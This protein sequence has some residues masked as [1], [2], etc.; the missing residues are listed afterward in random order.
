MAKYVWLGGTVNLGRFGTVRRGDVLNM[1]EKEEESIG[2]N[3]P[4]GSLDPRFRAFKDGEK[5][6]DGAGLD[7]PEGFEKLTK[8]GQA[9]AR[10]ASEE[11]RRRL[12]ALAQ[13][14]NPKGGTPGAGAAG[15]P[16]PPLTAEQQE[17]ARA[18]A[19]ERARR[20]QL[21]AANANTDKENFREMTKAELLEVVEEIRR[22]GTPVESIPKNASRNAV[23]RA[24]LVA[25]GLDTDDVPEDEGTGS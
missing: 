9:A 15:Q 11:T 20:Q 16:L 13:S 24:V 18:D 10:Q 7:L 8:E 25:K 5:A 21:E 2:T 1:T 22:E 23:L 4:G 14:V 12:E 17:A 19:A 3:G 6:V